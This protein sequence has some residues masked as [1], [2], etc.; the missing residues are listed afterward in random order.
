MEWEKLSKEELLERLAKAK[1]DL[2][3]VEEERMFVLS[4]TG[5]HVSGGTVRKYE[6]EVNRLRELVKAIEARLAQM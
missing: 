4:Q 5:L 3:E 6:E 2:E 1:E